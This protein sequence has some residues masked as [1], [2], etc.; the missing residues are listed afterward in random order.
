MHHV[1]CYGQIAPV[2]ESDFCGWEVDEP[3]YGGTATCVSGPICEGC[4]CEYGSPDINAHNWDMEHWMTDG[5]TTHWHPCKNTGCTARKDETSHNY[6]NWTYVNDSTHKGVCACGAETTEA[7]YDRWATKCGRQ[8]HCEKCDRDYGEIPEHEM[9][10]VYRNE[11]KHKPYGPWSP[12]DAGRHTARCRRCDRASAVDCVLIAVA[13]ADPDA[14]PVFLCPICGRR[15]GGA[16]LIAV[17]D[18]AAEGAVPG[19]DLV[20]FVS[21]EGEAVRWLTVAFEVGG[22]LVQPDGEM[23]VTLPAGALEG[24]GLALV[25]PN[26]EQTPIACE[27]DGE[28]MSFTLNFAPDD[29]PVQAAILALAAKD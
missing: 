4:R 25:A 12:D 26:G 19:G 11:E 20:V 22:R 2:E 17:P 3:H 29:A 9:Y 8:P 18:A 28:A 24:V 15:E 14:E 1:V 5:G 21:P 6:G 13:Q 7:H 16:A 10:Y 23:T 27:A